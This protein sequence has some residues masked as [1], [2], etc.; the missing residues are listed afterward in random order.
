MIGDREPGL[1]VGFAGRARVGKDTA[2]AAAGMHRHAFADSI[3]AMAS[4][5]D[6]FLAESGVRLNELLA[7][8]G[9]DKAKSEY[10]EVRYLLA[11]LGQGGR[12]VVDPNIWIWKMLETV[13]YFVFDLGQDHAIT[14]VRYPNE[15]E[16]IKEDGGLL[17]LIE[18]PGIPTYDHPSECALD[19]WTDWD[20]VIVNDGTLKEFEESVRAALRGS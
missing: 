8:H 20:H 18:R 4:Y 13:P 11:Q 14:D 16:A 12:E 19:D 9:W 10:N 1:F 5:I 3:R 15:C 2:A 6:P 17:V 7:Q